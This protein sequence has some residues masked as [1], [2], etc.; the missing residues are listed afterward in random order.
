M[1]AQTPA[2]GL[3]CHVPFCAST[4]DFCAFYQEKPRRGDLD[5][6]LDAMEREFAL[7]PQDRTVETVFWGGGTPG[8][9]AAKDLERLGCSM[10]DRLV[11]PPEEWTIE[12]APST[13]K[14]D[15]LAVLKD[16]GVTR[17][18]MGVQSF[19]ADLLESLGRLHNPRQIDTAWERIRDAK[20]PQTNL[21]LMFAIPNQTMEQWTSDI[22][23]AAQ[24][25][26][27]HIS[28]YCLTFEE[29]TA[30]YVKLAKGQLRIDEDREVRFYQAGWNRL[31]A[32]GYR[33]YEISNFAQPG[34]ECGHNL[35]TW[36]M[37]EWI[38]CGPS[39]ASQFGGERYQRPANLEQWI[40][41]MWT[42]V[43]PKEERVMLNDRI[44]L[45]DSLVFGLRMNE[46]VDLDKL[47]NRHPGAGDLTRL[48]ALL[49]R[50]VAEGLA[51]NSSDQLKLTGE[52]RLLAD[53][54]GSGV[55]EAMEV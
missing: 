44:L 52:G 54:I 7:L 32:L 24:L 8:L 50:L 5:R 49:E 41:G 36:R 10:L 20:F 16:M 33:Q 43:P 23:A 14:A 38:G 26:P 45:A 17:I 12:M 4:C 18:S 11:Q 13:V 47:K 30:L 37:Q 2:L 21:D 53:A 15:K 3:Y 51:M 48:D 46:G 19:D 27:D 22:E 1:S 31:Q 29:D 35:N 28:T 40:E 34:K 25:G 55:I 42:E 6:Y 9:L 39:A